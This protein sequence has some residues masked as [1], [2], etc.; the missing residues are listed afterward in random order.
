MAQY[1]YG[2]LLSSGKIIGIKDVP[3]DRGERKEWECVCPKCGM[4]LTARR[5]EKN[6]DHFAHKP[7]P[8]FGENIFGCSSESANESALH[9]M[10]KQLLVDELTN[11]EAYFTCPTIEVCLNEIRL[12]D[13]PE[14]IITQ[15]PRTIQYKKTY[16]LVYTQ[17]ILEQ[18]FEDFRPDIVILTSEGPYFVEIC[19]THS[20]DTSKRN[21]VKK[22]GIPMLEINLGEFC[23]QRISRNDLRDILI[24][25]IKHKKW[26]VRPREDEVLEWGR[27][28]YNGMSLIKDYRARQKKLEEVFLE[29]NYAE[30]VRRNEGKNGGYTKDTFSKFAYYKEGTPP[31]FFVNIPI[32]GEF[33]FGC[34]R[35]V[36]QSAIFDKQVFRR[37]NDNASINISSIF[38]KIKRRE[39]PFSSF[40]IPVDYSLTSERVWIPDLLDNVYLGTRVIRTYMNYLNDLGFI[41]VHYCHDDMYDDER[42]WTRYGEWAIVNERCSISPPNK[43]FAEALNNAIKR[44]GDRRYLPNV[45]ELIYEELRDYRVERVQLL[46]ERAAKNLEEMKRREEEE[47]RRA[48]EEQKKQE[49]AKIQEEERRKAK[50]QQDKERILHEDYEQN[51]YSV[52]DMFGH[53]YVLCESC[54]K[55]YLTT[56]MAYYGGSISRNKGLCRYCNQKRRT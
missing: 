19:V 54:N 17:A 22:H 41:E 10:A 56:D 12:D 11:G 39:G 40:Q 46:R 24:T 52:V 55:P 4:G 48:E 25:S 42:V 7:N 28:T 20:V 44:L 53:R 35:R 14:N 49:E 43:A 8:L 13:I 3:K 5:G 32:T 45:D 27:N 34:D 51:D 23:E 36:W 33:V 50:I 1:V 37:K 38:G 6:E 18:E 9:Q 29:K 15:I 47:K 31:P 21:K 16:N 26:I 2:K 30:R